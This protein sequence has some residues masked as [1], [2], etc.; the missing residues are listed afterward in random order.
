MCAHTQRQT[1]YPCLPLPCYS[2]SW[3][4]F[5]YQT[6]HNEEILYGVWGQTAGVDLKGDTA[7]SSGQ[8]N[9]PDTYEPGSLLELLSFEL[10][11]RKEV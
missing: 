8:L 3:G 6:W 11:S 1:P 7:T 2:S 5:A 10:S 9:K 4:Y